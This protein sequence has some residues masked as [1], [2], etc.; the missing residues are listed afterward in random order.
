MGDFLGKEEGFFAKKD[1][2]P[3]LLLVGNSQE[4]F[5]EERP[6]NV[7][8]VNAHQIFLEKVKTYKRHLILD[9][10]LWQVLNELLSFLPVSPVWKAGSLGVVRKAQVD[11]KSLEVIES[12]ET[13]VDLENLEVLGS[14]EGLVIASV[15]SRAREVSKLVLELEQML[16]SSWIL[17]TSTPPEQSVVGSKK[18][19]L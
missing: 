17:L 19:C 6:E 10:F 15:G 7:F 14:K 9:M 18:Q 1:D 5:D 2:S 12:R 8:V 3:P 13:Q 16:P 11:L 4:V